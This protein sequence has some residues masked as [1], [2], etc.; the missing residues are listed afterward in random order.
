MMQVTGEEGVTLD[1][2]VRYQQS[3]FV[4][5]IYLQQ[6]GFDSVDAAVPLERQKQMFTLIQRVLNRDYRFRDK[7]QV[8]EVFIRLTGLFKNLNYA[9]QDSSDYHELINQIEELR[10]DP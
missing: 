5:M 7:E 8:R 10:A 1:D 2:F 6:D 9:E 3:L 4:D